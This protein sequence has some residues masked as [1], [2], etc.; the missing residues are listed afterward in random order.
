MTN[1]LQQAITEQLMT[2]PA[3][4]DKEAERAHDEQARLSL[5]AA[6][7]DWRDLARHW[8]ELAGEN[9]E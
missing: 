5:R 7:A 2:A 6:A 4:C 3:H 1:L 8:L 9:S